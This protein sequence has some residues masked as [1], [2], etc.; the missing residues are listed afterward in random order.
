MMREA[1]VRRL[2]VTAVTT[3]RT[4]DGTRTVRRKI[5]LKR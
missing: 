3:I 5:T 2:K 1:G 4:A